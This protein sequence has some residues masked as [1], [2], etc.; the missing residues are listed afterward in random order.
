VSRPLRGHP[1]VRSG[2]S[3]GV[4][5]RSRHLRRGRD[6]SRVEAACST[7]AWIKRPDTRRAARPPTPRERLRRRSAHPTS[8]CRNSS[9][10]E[11]PA[12]SSR[13]PTTLPQPTRFPQI[14]S[15][16]PLT[17]PFRFRPP[18]RR[19]QLPLTR[20]RR[21]ASGP[22][23]SRRA[24]PDRSTWQVEEGGSGAQYLSGRQ[25]FPDA[26]YEFNRSGVFR[27][28]V[29]ADQLSLEGPVTRLR[30]VGVLLLPASK[31]DRPQVTALQSSWVVAFRTDERGNLT[32]RTPIPALRLVQDGLSLLGSVHFGRESPLTEACLKESPAWHCSTSVTALLDESISSGHHLTLRR[33]STT[34]I[35]AP[36][37]MRSRFAFRA[38][39]MSSPTARGSRSRG[40]T[41]SRGP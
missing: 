7:S 39:T 11:L 30:N 41:T 18:P 26:F 14:A 17:S 32:V 9:P 31:R 10:L 27:A 2:T 16:A 25:L 22:P 34:S 21:P 20:C 19:C 40:A 6:T 29:T 1:R 3:R 38:R 35:H 23:A 12:R 36:G 33:S 37:S 13:H 4:A 15:T 5:R 24:W 8:S 28:D